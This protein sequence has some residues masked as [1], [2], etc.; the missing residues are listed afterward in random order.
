[1]F[2]KNAFR[3][4]RGQGILLVCWGRGFVYGSFI[5]ARRARVRGSINVAMPVNYSILEKYAMTLG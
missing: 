2:L 3:I 4:I 1:M 5:M